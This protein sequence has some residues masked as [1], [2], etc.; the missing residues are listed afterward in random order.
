MSKKGKARRYLECENAELRQQ[1]EAAQARI[2]ELEAEVKFWKAQVDSNEN[3]VIVADGDD[4][5]AGQVAGWSRAW[6]WWIDRFIPLSNEILQLTSIWSR[7]ETE[8]LS[9]LGQRVPR[10]VVEYIHAEFSAHLGKAVAL[11][12]QAGHDLDM[13]RAESLEL[14]NVDVLFRQ[15]EALFEMIA[16]NDPE[17]EGIRALSSEVGGVAQMAEMFDHWR[18]Q[19]RLPG[20]KGVRDDTLWLRAAWLVQQNIA[21]DAT[22][23]EIRLSILKRIA[24]RTGRGVDDWQPRPENNEIETKVYRRLMTK[25]AKTRPAQFQSDLFAG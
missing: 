3:V 16:G 20:P 14:I 17:A 5:T 22:P 6:A 4:Y 7:I 21:P 19:F 9:P 18:E 11:A 12:E 24:E 2:D 25:T 10:E 15:R 1:L 23:D 8:A 13:D